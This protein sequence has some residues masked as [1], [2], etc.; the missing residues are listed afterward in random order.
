MIW[1]WILAVGVTATGLTL[2]TMFPNDWQIIMGLFCGVV[3]LI[4][5]WGRDED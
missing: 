1:R 5:D 4:G 2:G 3:F